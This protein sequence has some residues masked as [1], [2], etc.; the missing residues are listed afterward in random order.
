MQQFNK[1][2]LYSNVIKNLLATTYLPLIRSVREGDYICEG[3]FYVFKCEFVKCTKSGF[4]GSKGFID[5]DKIANWTSLR[6]FHFGE[7]DDKLSTNYISNCEGYDYRTHE[8]LGQ[9]LRN[10]R[11]MYGLNLLPMYNCFSNQPL[12]NHIIKPKKI[13]HTSTYKNT[14]IYK[15][16]IKFNQDYTI[17]IEN[18]GKTTIAPAFLRYNNLV[19]QNNTQYGNGIDIT[20]QYISLHAYDNIH[21]Y[22]NTSFGK[23]IKVRFDN[24]PHTKNLE[25]LN[26]TPVQKEEEVQS[27]VSGETTVEFDSVV[28]GSIYLLDENDEQV[29]NEDGNQPAILGENKTI[30]QESFKEGKSASDVVKIVYTYIPYTR[31]KVSY[32][33][34][35]E[36]CSQFA[37]VENTLYMLIQVP[38][39]F[40]QN[41]VVLEGDYTELEAQKIVDGMYVDKLPD[42]LY[43]KYYIHDLNLMTTT[44]EQIL[45]FSPLLVEYLLW[46]VMC[47]LDTINNDFDRLSIDLTALRSMIPNIDD[48]EI[49]LNLPNFWVSRYRQI[50]SDFISHNST[51]IVQDNLGYA[52]KDVEA[53]I[54]SSRQQFTPYD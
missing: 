7:K 44:T 23:P 28:Y 48:I 46:N 2:S 41:I 43:D 25:V 27:F 35:N 26:N 45:P 47:T 16:P 33:I 15:I 9:Y 52:T 39:V 49:T 13:E 54:Y 32:E 14:K 50:I 19:K 42:F 8:R 20:N 17:C 51:N 11:D 53:F 3:R 30:I 24:Y 36:M 18:L 22:V 31:N 5:T 4:V 38:K 10:L 1:V 37:D 34:T 21:N 29:D 40:N 6:E 12:E